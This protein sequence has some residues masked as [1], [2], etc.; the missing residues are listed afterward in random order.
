MLESGWWWVTAVSCAYC[1]CGVYHSLQVCVHFVKTLNLHFVLY[2]YSLWYSYIRFITDHKGPPLDHAVSRYNPAHVFTT[3]SLILHY[4]ACC[5]Q[6]QPNMIIIH[7]F[8]YSDSD[9]L[10]FP[11]SVRIFFYWPSN[12]NFPMQNSI[13]NSFIFIF[14]YHFQHLPTFF[15]LK[16]CL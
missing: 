11:Q 5:S 2:L 7:I 8:K 10:C 3:F 6:I 16:L 15:K 14:F 13:E 1:I 12:I 4:T 9:P